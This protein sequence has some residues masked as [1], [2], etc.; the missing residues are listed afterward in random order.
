[1]NPSSLLLLYLH[2]GIGNVYHP[3]FRAE[4]NGTPSVTVIKK[5]VGS[6]FLALDAPSASLYCLYDS[7]MA[8]RG[9][10]AKFNLVG[11]RLG[12]AIHA[13]KPKVKWS[14]P[15]FPPIH[16]DCLP[17]PHLLDHM[18]KGA[19]T[20]IFCNL[21][22]LAI[23]HNA[24]VEQIQAVLSACPRLRYTKV[25][26]RRSSQTKVL[27]READTQAVDL[28]VWR[29]DSSQNSPLANCRWKLL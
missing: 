15:I 20:K 24:S 27:K 29:K 7:H 12:H 11:I 26:L 4:P 16:P 13:N 2:D 14:Q 6:L 21:T 18:E 3:G 10:D 17:H 19:W 22:H 5:A 1:M 28:N 9:P 8:L 23:T 25:F